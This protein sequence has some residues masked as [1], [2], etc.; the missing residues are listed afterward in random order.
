MVS[1]LPIS[2]FTPPRCNKMQLDASAPEK[3]KES[4]FKLIYS[5]TYIKNGI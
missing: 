2:P 5:N 1:E 4:N 3:I